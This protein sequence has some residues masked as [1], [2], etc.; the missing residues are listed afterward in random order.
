MWKNETG[1]QSIRHGKRRILVLFRSRLE[2]SPIRTSAIE[3]MERTVIC[4][5]HFPASSSDS[6]VI[7]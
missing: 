4:F 5:S 1:F 7:A 2:I 6:L 3:K